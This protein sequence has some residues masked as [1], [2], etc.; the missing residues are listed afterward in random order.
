M[1]KNVYALQLQYTLR[2]A[3]GYFFQILRADWE[4][5][6]KFTAGK[7][8][9]VGVVNRKQN[10][11]R[12]QYGQRAE[13]WRDIKV[14]ARR[15]VKVLAKIVDDSPLERGGTVFARHFIKDPVS[16]SDIE[17]Q[18]ISHVSDNDSKLGETVE[19]AGKDQAEAMQSGF[20]M[21][22]PLRAVTRN[23]HSPKVEK[24]ASPTA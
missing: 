6:E 11:V 15:D 21:P 8:G 16:P 4:R 5:V 13:K 1:S 7:V 10:V 24:R 3:M 9:S 23:R 22:I 12:T 17:R 20:G 14:T 2:V 18:V 19:Y